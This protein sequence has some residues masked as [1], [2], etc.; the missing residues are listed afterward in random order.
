MIQ[1]VEVINQI[2]KEVK[3]RIGCYKST[4]K[5]YSNLIT[6]LEGGWDQVWSLVCYF[7]I[8]KVIIYSLLPKKKIFI[9]TFS[10][11]QFLV[12]GLVL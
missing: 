1:A 10:S 11:Q 6:F 12:H 4:K 8:V 5:A 7:L 9:M 2:Q 3:E